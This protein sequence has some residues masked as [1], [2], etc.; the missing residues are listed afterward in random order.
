M[1]NLTDRKLLKNYVLKE[2]KGSGQISDV[3]RA[4][5]LKKG[6]DV[7]VKI[8]RRDASRNQS[9]LEYFSGEANLMSTLEHPNIVR[10]Y[11]FC[12]DGDLTFIVMDWVEG[13]NLKEAIHNRS[14][15]FSLEETAHILEPICS[16]L[17]YAHTQNIIHCDIKPANILIDTTGRVLLSDFG[18]SRHARQ[19][20]TG[21]TPPYMAPEQF[22]G[23]ALSARTDIYALGVTTYELLSGGKVP[24]TGDTPRTQGTT[25]RDR[26]YWEMLNLPYPQLS[27]FN[28]VIPAQVEEVIQKSL[29]RAP[30]KR[31]KT[32]MDF[33]S[34][35]ES[36]AGCISPQGRL[37]IGT[38]LLPE[39][40]TPKKRGTRQ[41]AER[42]PRRQTG[43]RTPQRRSSGA[44][45]RGAH[46]IGIGG[47]WRGYKVPISSQTFTIGRLSTSK[48]KISD[49]GVSR[50]HATILAA[51]DGFY[52]RDDNSKLGTYLNGAPVRGPRKLRSRDVIE[53]GYGHKF[54]FRR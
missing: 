13:S 36:A 10:F 23:K 5:D 45:I 7:A 6:V 47:Q 33:Y 30:L 12:R 52:I 28:R 40:V 25:L 32:A 39:E 17:N 35:F 34:Q 51:R 18:I 16:A 50:A 43:Q 1:E 15:P 44:P 41:K 20:T 54:E 46:L 37:D 42:T 3:Y 38:T 31:Q 2:R 26:I 48:L 8:L 27:K 53:I 4:R 49:R 11:E 22:S 9:F 21:G 29:S 24:F 14:K 19:H